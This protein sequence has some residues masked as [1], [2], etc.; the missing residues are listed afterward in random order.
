MSEN[1]HT[2]G[3]CAVPLVELLASVPVGARFVEKVAHCHHRSHPVGRLCGEAAIEIARLSSE[4]AAIKAQN[5]ELLEALQ[6]LVG[7]YDERSRQLA[8]TAI[9]KATG[10]D[11]AT[12]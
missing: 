7:F 2:P 8:Y 5:A 1:K 4:L 10:Q 3:P 11:G 6:R 12:P 9:A